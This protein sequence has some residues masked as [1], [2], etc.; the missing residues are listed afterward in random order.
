MSVTLGQKVNL[1][2][3]VEDSPSCVVIVFD[4]MSDMISIPWQNAYQIASA[5]D[6]VIKDARSHFVPTSIE[7]TY[8]E[9]AQIRFNQTSGLVHIL[10]EWTDRVR[11]TSLDA[12]YLVSQTLK[13]YTQDAEYAEIGIHFEYIPGGRFLKAIH[14]TKTDTVQRVR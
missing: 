3:E 10:T 1:T 12:L 4:R 2:I 9:Q 8:R 14:N 6:T 7:V 13:K 5:I 11:F